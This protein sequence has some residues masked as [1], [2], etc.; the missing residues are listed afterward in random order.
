VESVWPGRSE[1]QKKGA[2]ADDSE[3]AKEEEEEVI[4]RLLTG[5]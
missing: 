1:L 2:R 3:A 5:N 4:V